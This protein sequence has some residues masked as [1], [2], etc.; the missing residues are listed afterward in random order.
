M[1]KKSV[2][3]VLLLSLILSACTQSV[4]GTFD[5]TSQKVYQ[6]GLALGLSEGLFLKT[7]LGEDDVTFSNEQQDYQDAIA[8]LD[9]YSQALDK[10]GGQPSF[11]G[12]V[13]LGKILLQRNGKPRDLADNYTG[14]YN[15]TLNLIP[16]RSQ[17]YY[18]FA[19]ALAKTS[20]LL[21]RFK[22]ADGT[23]RV[24]GADFYL[25]GLKE[26][27][28]NVSGELG[29]FDKQA[30]TKLIAY[31]TKT[32]TVENLQEIEPLLQTLLKSLPLNQ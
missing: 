6:V 7:T 26:L 29:L 21:K 16:E 23:F 24:P 14:L 17:W 9:A 22:N 11:Q 13:V 25:T 19:Y 27:G 5:K 2:A 12:N 30:L 4:T 18:K 15:S 8:A 3:L 31:D 28:T 20:E 32:L 1:F 10:F